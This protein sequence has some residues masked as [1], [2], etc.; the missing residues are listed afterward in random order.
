VLTRR[1]AGRPANERYRTE[2]FASWPH[3]LLM[4]WTSVAEEWKIFRTEVRAQWTL[5][6]D[7]QLEAIAGRRAHLAAQIRISYGFAADEVER[8]ILIFEARNHF[9]R[10]VSLR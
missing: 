1:N 9:L 10:D 7:A 6:T 8:Q 4:D 5:L 3:A 2:V